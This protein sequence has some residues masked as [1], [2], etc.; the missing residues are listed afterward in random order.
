MKYQVNVTKADIVHCDMKSITECAVAKAVQRATG[1]PKAH[2]GT[3]G[4]SAT[5]RGA[6]RSFNLPQEASKAII[7]LIGASMPFGAFGRWLSVRP[8]SFEIEL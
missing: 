5:V 6:H 8:F 1:D 4:G 2:V 7:A 3:W